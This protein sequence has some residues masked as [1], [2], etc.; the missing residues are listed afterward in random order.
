MS[1]TFS[2][3][4]AAGFLGSLHCTAMCGPFVGYYSL[5]AKSPYR[6]HAGYHGGRLVSYV[7]LGAI[8]GMLGRSVLFLGEVVKAQQ[9]MIALMGGLMI[10]SGVLYWL[11]AGKGLRA[12]VLSRKIGRLL[13][14]VTAERNHPA[15]A[16]LIGLCSTLLP[17]G[18]LYAFVLAAGAS[19]DPLI[20]MW[21]MFGFW[22]GTLP[23]LLG[24]GL[25]TRYCS[26]AWLLRFQKLVPVFLIIFGLLALTGKWTALPAGPG[27]GPGCLHP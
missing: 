12:P 10:L 22:L 1:L 9:V 8:A 4:V 21:L 26:Q 2:L 3:V 25:V 23:A 19:A 16:T 15:T 13:R 20:A 6:H 7:A 17:C 24:L 11:P 14:A 27:Q 5:G 18:F